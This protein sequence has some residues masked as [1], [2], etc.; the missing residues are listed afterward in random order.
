M[1]NAAPAVVEPNQ[2]I[3]QIV[4]R[5]KPVISKHLLHTGTSEETFVAQFGNAL[6]AAPK[7]WA[8]EPETVLGAALRCAQLNLAP[9]TEAN[10]AWVIPYKTVATF[11]LGYG[12]VIELA[13]RAQPGI[14]FEGHPVYPGDIF[15]LDYGRTPPLKHKP[16]LARRPA[17]PRGGPAV[18]WYVKVTYPDGSEQVHALDRDGVEYHRGFSKQPDGEMWSKSYDAAALK[19]VVMDMKRWLPHSPQMTAAIAADEQVYDVRTMDV[20]DITQPREELAPGAPMTADDEADAAWIAEAS[21]ADPIG[22][23]T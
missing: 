5:Y 16:H 2:A 7:L 13:R 8:C 23:P 22:G 10:L 3:V 1:S 12:G 14:R 20:A 4:N 11:Q 6:R 18:A 17:K 15:D 19:S 9:N 21:G